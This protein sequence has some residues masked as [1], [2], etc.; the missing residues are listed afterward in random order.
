ML[1]DSVSGETLLP[2]SYMTV[3]SLCSPMMDGRKR[4]ATLI[5]TLIPFKKARL[6]CLFLIPV[7]FQR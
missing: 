1:V 4:Q 2:G 5:R 7:S 3:F 6:P